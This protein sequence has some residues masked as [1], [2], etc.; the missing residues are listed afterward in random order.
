MNGL[1]KCTIVCRYIQTTIYVLRY[2]GDGSSDGETVTPNML[3]KSQSRYVKI[4]TFKELVDSKACRLDF[5]SRKFRM[6]KKL[7]T[8]L[9]PECRLWPKLGLPQV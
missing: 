6:E 9:L 8:V 2:I 1:K 7:C 5:S 3:K 4:T